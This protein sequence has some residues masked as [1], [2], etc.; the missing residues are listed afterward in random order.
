[1]K[2]FYSRP[3]IPGI[4]FY[5]FTM[6]NKN[7]WSTR[8]ARLLLFCISIALFSASVQAAPC[9]GTRMPGKYR[10]I[11]GAQSYYLQK[12]YLEHSHGK[13]R[14]LQH[15]LL[16]S[17]G[18]FDWL[19]IDL[20]V[21]GGNIKHFPVRANKLEYTTSFAGGYG[22]RLKLY[23]NYKIRSVLGF[24]HISVHP[25]K[26][27]ANDA[28]NRAILDDW[29]FS[30]LA[31]YDISRFTPYVG[32]RWSR[33]DYIHWAN[34]DRQRR[35]SEKSK[36]YGLIVGCDIDLIKDMWLNFEAQSFDSQAFAVS[37][38]YRY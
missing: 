13:V 1:M 16:A 11:C 4:K 27:Y 2:C 17:Y 15:F 25:R 8:F 23:D 33:V 35:M 3:L 29:Q 18:I 21:G 37:I 14:S 19:C 36:S 26:V 30:L 24:Q 34:D 6:R 12:R 38:N 10:T 20:K 7:R 5:F 31:S 9:Y 22:V 32:T 28:K